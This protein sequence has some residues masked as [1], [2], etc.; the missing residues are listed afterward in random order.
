MW[1]LS[2]VYGNR[3]SWTRNSSPNSLCLSVSHSLFLLIIL[4]RL[5]KK[6]KNLFLLAQQEREIPKPKTIGNYRDHS[7]GMR[8]SS[9]LFNDHCRHCTFL[10]VHHKIL[11]S[12]SFFNVV[13]IKLWRIF[14]SVRS[15]Y[16]LRFQQEE[17][18]VK[19]L[20]VCCIS[21]RDK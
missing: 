7:E 4:K 20:F 12:F 10:L 1:H 3:I 5:K 19:F 9:W 18:S 13:A 8:L 15:A 16:T 6:N 14:S 17:K 11:F 21:C 2:N